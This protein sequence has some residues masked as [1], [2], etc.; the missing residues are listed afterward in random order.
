MNKQA[1]SQQTPWLNKFARKDAQQY[2][3]HDEVLQF[4]K[5]ASPTEPERQIRD[6]ICASVTAVVTDL[7]PHSKVPKFH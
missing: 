1:S 4:E 7:W 3:G 2:W 5:W 6:S